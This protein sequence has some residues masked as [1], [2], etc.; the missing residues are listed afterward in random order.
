[1]VFLTLSGKMK[2]L[3]QE[4]MIF[5]FRRKLK[6]DLSQKSMWKCNIPTSVLKRWPSQITHPEI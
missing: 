4:N 6:D 5:F 3:F 1:M 2:F